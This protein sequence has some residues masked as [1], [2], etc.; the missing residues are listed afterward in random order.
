[1]LWWSKAFSAEGVFAA[2][3]TGF[4]SGQREAPRQLKVLP[5]QLLC[6]REL[7]QEPSLK[8]VVHLVL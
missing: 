1:M 6:E 4:G 3:A 5:E 8:T 2:T 7:E